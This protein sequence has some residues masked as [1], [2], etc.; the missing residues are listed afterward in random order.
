M[1]AAKGMCTMIPA[2]Q[3]SRPLVGA[4]IRRCSLLTAL[5]IIMV[6]ALIPSK[7]NQKKDKFRGIVVHTGPKAISVKSQ[8]NIYVVR[9]F[10]YTPELEKKINAKPPATGKKVTVHYFRGTDIATKVD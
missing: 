8:E 7:E 4:R 3:R 6:P 2:R 1:A 10:N 9:T 5:L